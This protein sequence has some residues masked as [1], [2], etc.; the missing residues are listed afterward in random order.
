MK[1]TELMHFAKGWERWKLL[2]AANPAC[3]GASLRV[4]E[5]RSIAGKL[6]GAF[7]KLVPISIISQVRK[8]FLPCAC[9][10]S[11]RR[12]EFSKG[13]RWQSAM[14]TWNGDLIWTCSCAKAPWGQI[15]RCFT[16]QIL[17][18]LLLAP[19]PPLWTVLLLGETNSSPRFWNH[20][21]D[22]NMVWENLSQQ[23]WEDIPLFTFTELW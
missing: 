12:K 1:G 3:L 11:F 9:S 16:L 2:V 8:I 17:V 21:M 14:R 5:H 19:S 20:N 22:F 7:W 13:I 15:H 10:Q 18:G 23:L 4:W 6:S